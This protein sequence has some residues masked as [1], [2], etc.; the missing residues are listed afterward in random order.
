MRKPGAL[1]LRLAIPALVAWLV[2][3]IVIGTDVAGAFAII[4]WALAGAG[5]AIALLTR[6]SWV[7]VASLASLLAAVCLTAVAV[8][9]PGRHPAILADAATAGQRVTVIGVTTSTALPGRGSFALTVTTATAK[10]GSLSGS[11]PMLVFGEGATD[12]LGIGTTVTLSGTITATDLSD[13]TSYVFFSE[14]AP[15]VIDRKSVV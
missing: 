7:A 3:A 4:A 11:I 6:W 15:S 14:S 5:L 13:E 10:S 9:T 1:D 12:R 8:Q 2:V